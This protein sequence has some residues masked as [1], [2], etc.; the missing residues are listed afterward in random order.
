MDISFN[1]VVE[2]VKSF[3]RFIYFG[4]LGLIGTFVVSLAANPSLANAHVTI[5]GATVSV[6]FVIVAGLSGLAKLIDRYVR[7]SE[8]ND[9]NGIAP[10]FLQK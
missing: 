6:G 1:A 8:N 2:V 3:A 10:S 9:L 4:V 7:S 5:A